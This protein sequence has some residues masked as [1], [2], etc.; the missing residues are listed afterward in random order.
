MIRRLLLCLFTTLLF[1][2]IA[3]PTQAK[4]NAVVAH[5]FWA[6]GCPH[7]AK[8]K[9]FLHALQQKYSGLEIKD[10]EITGK[11]ENLQLLVKAGEE[12]SADVSGVPFTIIGKQ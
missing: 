4:E 6:S 5:F 8:E 3:W 7:C 1:L 12:L 10:Y 9:V 2:S 11:K